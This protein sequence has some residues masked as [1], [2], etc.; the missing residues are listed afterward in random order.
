MFADSYQPSFGEL[1]MVICKHTNSSTASV[2]QQ[3]NTSWTKDDKALFLDK[4]CSRKLEVMVPAQKIQKRGERLCQAV[5]EAFGR[6]GI[7]AGERAESLKMTDE[8]R[9]LYW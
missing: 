5:V 9:V 8:S 7:R 2:L 1:E 4:I 6:E 3:N